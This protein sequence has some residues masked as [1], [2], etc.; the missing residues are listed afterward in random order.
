M[1]E[2]H[3]QRRLAA[4]LANADTKCEPEMMRAGWV[5]RAKK[6]SLSI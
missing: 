3:L 1:A 2:E 4:I 6:E 5:E